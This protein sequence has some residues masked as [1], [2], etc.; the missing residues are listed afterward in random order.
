MDQ[1]DESMK[2]NMLAELLLGGIT[3][4][5][6]HT[7]YITATLD[8]NKEQLRFAFRTA[9]DMYGFLSVDST[10]GQTVKEAHPYSTYGNNLIDLHVP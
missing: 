1:L 9:H 2:E 7:Q 8:F 6:K 5:L 4:Q 10:L 3:N